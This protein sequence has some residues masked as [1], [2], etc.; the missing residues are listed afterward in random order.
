[1]G[2][3]N[4]VRRRI[5]IAL[6]CAIG[7]MGLAAACNRTQPCSDVEK[8]HG[9][10]LP[11][12]ARNCQ[13]VRAKGMVDHGVLSMFELNQKDLM[14]FTNQLI[15]K[16]TQLPTR[17]LNGDPCING[18]NVWPTNSQTFVP[19][20]RDLSY[21]VRHGQEKRARSNPLAVAPRRGTG[22]MWKSGT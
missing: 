12:S 5:G 14:L 21:L 18:W 16:S 8:A 19:G 20:N 7:L 9:L 22:F 17:Q 6:L 15:V 2:K 1:M 11:S 10:R 4:L 3:C 13:T